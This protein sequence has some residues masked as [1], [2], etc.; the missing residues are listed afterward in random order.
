MVVVRDCGEG[1][2]G[3]LIDTEFPFYK[4]KRVLTLEAE[5]GG[6]LEHKFHTS[7]GNRVR[8]HLREKKKK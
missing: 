6:S 8:P 5:R 4:M 7:L 3:S 1:K 2:N